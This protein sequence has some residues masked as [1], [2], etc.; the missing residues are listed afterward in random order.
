LFGSTAEAASL[1]QEPESFGEGVEHST[2]ATKLNKEMG[3]KKCQR[4]TVKRMKKI[5]GNMSF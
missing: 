4:A 5:A 3:A 2:S 1:G